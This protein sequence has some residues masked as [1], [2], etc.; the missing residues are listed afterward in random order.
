M[1]LNEA[2]FLAINGARTP[3]LDPVMIAFSVIGLFPLTFF[4]ALPLWFR[5]RRAD[6]IDFVLLLAVA[7]VSVLLLKLAFDVDRP[8]GLGTVLEAPFDDR[9]DPGFPSGHAT[10]AFV[11]AW[12]LAIRLKDRRWTVLLLSYASVMG[13]SRVYVGAHWPSDVVAGAIL[14]VAWAIG[15]DFLAGREGYRA[16]RDK[17]L[18]ALR[19]R[20]TPHA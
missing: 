18:G 8:V 13:V 10:R 12:L 3:F 4:G 19:P 11:A 16:F 20:H 9:S 1:G 14:G 5:G 2:I 6:A 15:F 7:E 17:L